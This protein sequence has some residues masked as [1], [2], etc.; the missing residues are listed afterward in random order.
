MYVRNKGFVQLEHVIE[1]DLLLQNIFSLAAR[2][3]LKQKC[4]EYCTS[5]SWA[6]QEGGECVQP[7]LHSPIYDRF[8]Q[9]LTTCSTLVPQIYTIMIA[10]LYGSFFVIFG[11]VIS[12]EGFSKFGL[13]VKK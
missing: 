10:M 4:R 13:F 12:D 8:P 3:L 11:R 9:N 7:R 6:G 2:S 1:K 5:T